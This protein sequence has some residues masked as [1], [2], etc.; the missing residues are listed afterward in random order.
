VIETRYLKILVAV[1]GFKESTNAAIGLAKNKSTYNS[2]ERYE[3]SI[4]GMNILAKQLLGSTASGVMT[5]AHCTVVE[6]RLHY[7]RELFF[8]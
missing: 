5:Y 7:D 6:V 8:F 3:A 4:R 2:L 1:D